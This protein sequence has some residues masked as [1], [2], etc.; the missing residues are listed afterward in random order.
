M[1]EAN[2]MEIL[3]V[4]SRQAS[5]AFQNVQLIDELKAKAYENEQFQKEVLR[6][7]EEE[8]KHISHELHDQVI[9]A[10]VGLKYQIANIQ[11]TVGI[12][13]GNRKQ[14]KGNRFAGRYCESDSNHSNAVSE[15]SPACSRLGSYSQHSLNLNSF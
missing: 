15:P 12:T 14:S 4:V 6:A 5:I 2:D 7:R 11:S 8:R 10:L 9:Q 13:F 3:G 1:F